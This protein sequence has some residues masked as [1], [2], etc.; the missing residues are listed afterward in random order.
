MS[1]FESRISRRTLGGVTMGVAATGS[2]AYL[3]SAQDATPA[4]DATEATPEVAGV[5]SLADLENV[6]HIDVK[7]LNGAY[8]AYVGNGQEEGWYVFNVEN[9]SDADASFNLALLPEG[10]GASDLTS[11]VFQVNN[12]EVTEMPAWLGETQ[13]AGGTSVP[14][15]E[16]NSVLVKLTPGE[17]TMFSTSAQSKQ[18]PGNFKVLSAEELM[19][20][21]Q[22]EAAATPEGGSLYPEGFSS[23]FTISVSNAGIGAD[24]MP[25]QGLN[26]VGVRNDGD[27]PADLVVLHGTEA[28]DPAALADVAKSWMAGEETGFTLVGGMGALS[29]G[30]YGYME[31]TAESGVYLAFSS[32]VNASGTPQVDDG[33]LIAVPM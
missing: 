31:L 29:P 11:F 32:L 23:S 24:A 14:V 5:P 26:I 12:G 1:L 21:Y 4:M 16:T 20:L 30:N 7:V 2:L 9:T 25:A 6:T 28:G 19:E 17:W 18:G 3:V 15:G 13:F 8:A 27:V 33:V 22:V 10:T